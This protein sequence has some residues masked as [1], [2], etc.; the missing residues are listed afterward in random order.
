ML[1]A[2]VGTFEK[3]PDRIGRPTEKMDRIVGVP[4]KIGSDRFFDPI[5]PIPSDP[6]VPTSGWRAHENLENKNINLFQRKLLMKESKFS[7]EQFGVI[8]C[9]NVQI[10]IKN[11]LI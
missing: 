3:F 7:N 8:F 1:A 9:T 5:K 6:I 4:Q 2:E 10:Q 11:R